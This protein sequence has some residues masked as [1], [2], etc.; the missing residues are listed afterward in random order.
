[1][2]IILETRNLGKTFK[3]AK[4]ETIKALVGIS[5]QIRKEEFVAVVGSSGCGKT[6]LLRIFAGL[7]SKTSGEVF[8][9]GKLIDGPSRDVGVV[10]Q[11]PVLLPWRT[12]LQ[13]V[14]LPVEV[15]GLDKEAYQAK[16]M[17]LLKLTG[18]EGFENKF[19]FELSGG[20]Q[21]RNA[22]SRALVYDPDILLMDEPFGALDAMTREQM[23]LELLRIW[24]ESRKTIFFI[25]HSITEAVFLADRI[26]VLSPRPGR[27]VKIIELGLPRPRSLDLLGTSEFGDAVLE[28]RR[29]FNQRGVIE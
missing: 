12:A 9:K 15:L 13:N 29:Y 11:D 4:G 26:I 8:L 14:M 23:N 24:E 5:C 22:I 25:T 10:F 28:I 1:M 16:A 20:M 2:D 19:P 21:Q 27:I 6:T 17:D 18:L 7:I 3:S